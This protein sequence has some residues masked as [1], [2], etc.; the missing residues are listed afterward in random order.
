MNLSPHF[1]LAEAMRSNTAERLEIDNTP[2]A[3]LHPALIAVAE[4]LLEPIRATFQIPF[5]PNSWYRGSE[6]ERALCWSSF[7]KWCARRVQEPTAGQWAEYLARKS[8]PRGEA[9]DLDLPGI[10]NLRLAQWIAKNLTFD[11]LILEFHKKGDPNSGWVH[12]SYSLTQTRNQVLTIG[13]GFSL[14]GLP[15]TPLG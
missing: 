12:V 8:H 15:K 1:T 9:V 11:Q 7:L 13:K 3:S 2:A 5:A 14:K 10:S 4:N 6:L